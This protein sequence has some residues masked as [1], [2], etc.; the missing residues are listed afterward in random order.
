MNRRWL[1]AM[2]ARHARGDL[3]PPALPAPSAVT[4]GDHRPTPL[5]DRVLMVFVCV[6]VLGV[7][8]LAI[9]MACGCLT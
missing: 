7:T 6:A 8:V 2:N 3:M 5:L 4:L 1:A 9:V